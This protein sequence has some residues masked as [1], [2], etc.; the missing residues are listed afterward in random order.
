MRR[1]K[2]SSILWTLIS[3]GIYL[4]LTFLINFGF[5]KHSTQ[6]SLMTIGINVILAVSLNLILGMSGQFSLG[7]AGFMAIGAYSTAVVLQSVDSF[8]GFAIGTLIG[9]GLTTLFSL[10]IAVPTLRLKGDYLAIATLGAAEIIRSIITNLDSI[11]NG[12]AGISITTRY[13]SFGLLYFSII[14]CIFI[15]MMLNNSRFGRAWKSVREDDI[16]ASAMGINVTKYKVIAFVIGALFASLAGSLYT[17]YFPF[18]RPDI[19]DFNKS[20]DILVIVVLGGMGSVTGSVIAAFVLGAINILLEQYASLRMIIYALLLIGMM[21]LRPSGI[22]GNYE[23]SFE[24]R[25]K[26]ESI[27][28]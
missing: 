18:I 6:I 24:R 17:G 3:V 26:Y 21:V 16:A 7:H 15:I 20:V 10:I 19:F 9:L 14:M 5:I 22:L 13:T 2:K 12:A 8:A 1:I 28:D 4:G 27:E 11:T 25:K 23:F